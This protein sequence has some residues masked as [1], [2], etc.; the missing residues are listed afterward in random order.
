[1]LFDEILE[2]LGDFGPYQRRTFLLVGLMAIP[3]SW[4][5][6]LQVFTAGYADHWCYATETS[7]IN[8]SYWNLTSPDCEESIRHATIPLS[9]KPGANAEYESCHRY[10]F[11][12]TGF[13]F[14]PGVNPTSFTNKTMSCDAG[15]VFDRSQYK[16][17]II[18]D[19]SMMLF[20]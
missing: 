19:V 15:W 18:S 17:T 7:N 5:V 1:M 6:L 4:H 16:S 11:T 2:L 8:C 20:W 14:Y 9:T 13:E 3:T 12:G 10:N